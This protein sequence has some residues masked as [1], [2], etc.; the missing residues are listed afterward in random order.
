MYSIS[1]Y[2]LILSISEIR[3][4]SLQLK[5]HQNENFV[6]FEIVEENLISTQTSK[7]SG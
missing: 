1:I 4:Y 7:Y 5:I 3:N 2:E 6:I